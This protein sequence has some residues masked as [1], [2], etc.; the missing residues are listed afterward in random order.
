MNILEVEKSIEILN[1]SC[2][3]FVLKKEKEKE[4]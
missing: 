4:G 3:L 2:Y 1:F